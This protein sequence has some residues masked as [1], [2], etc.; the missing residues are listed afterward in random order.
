MKL[1]RKRKRNNYYYSY[2]VVYNKT[3]ITYLISSFFLFMIKEIKSNITIYKK[4]KKKKICVNILIN[5]IK[6]N[7]NIMITLSK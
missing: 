7:N 2:K 3:N 1:Y 5:A 4:K 6:K